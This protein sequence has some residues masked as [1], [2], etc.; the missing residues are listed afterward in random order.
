MNNRDHCFSLVG[1]IWFA[2]LV[3]KLVISEAVF[4]SLL[5]Q[6]PRVERQLFPVSFELRLRGRTVSDAVNI[7]LL[8]VRLQIVTGR[9]E[10]LHSLLLEL[11]LLLLTLKH[12]LQRAFR[13]PYQCLSHLLIFNFRL[14]LHGVQTRLILRDRAF[15]K[16]FSFL[17]GCQVVWCKYMLSLAIEKIS[18]VVV[19]GGAATLHHKVLVRVA[20]NRVHSRLVKFLIEISIIRHIRF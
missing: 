1:G 20:R 13:R 17:N 9:C 18:G 11:H 16:P 4:C 6:L 10:P 2:Q 12:V 3:C 5:P 14:A 19:G 15:L 8:R 7:G